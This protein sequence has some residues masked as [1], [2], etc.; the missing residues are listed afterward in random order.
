MGPK[1]SRRQGASK[2]GETSRALILG[3][4]GQAM[5]TGMGKDV[6][7]SAHRKQGDTSPWDVLENNHPWLQGDLR[8][9][10]KGPSF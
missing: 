4:R 8:E 5:P 6:G 3:R 1:T 9:G 2:R 10:I 7:S